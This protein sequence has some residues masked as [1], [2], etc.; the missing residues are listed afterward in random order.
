MGKV[1]LQINVEYTHWGSHEKR[2]K[3][4]REHEKGICDYI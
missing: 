3:N 1:S 4:G 2:K